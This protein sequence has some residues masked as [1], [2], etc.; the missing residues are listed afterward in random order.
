MKIILWLRVTTIWG[1]VLGRLRPTAL[2]WPLCG[3]FSHCLAFRRMSYALTSL[4]LL[5]LPTIRHLLYFF[6]KES[7]GSCRGKKGRPRN[8]NSSTTT[9][10]VCTQPDLSSEFQDRQTELHSIIPSQKEKKKKKNSLSRHR[11]RGQARKDVWSW[12]THHCLAQAYSQDCADVIGQV[13]SSPESP[14]L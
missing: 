13:A 10:G 1:T 12:L 2:G 5:R 9:E 8:S 14:L 6:A 4:N 11:E 3:I 7:P